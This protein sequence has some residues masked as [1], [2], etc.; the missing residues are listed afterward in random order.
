VAHW[1]SQQNR[2]RPGSPG[3]VIQ[4]ITV[5][6]RIDIVVACPT[7]AVIEFQAVGEFDLALKEPKPVGV[8]VLYQLRDDRGVFFGFT[9]K[10]RRGNPV[11]IQNVPAGGLVAGS[12][13]PEILAVSIDETGVTPRLKVEAVGPLGTGQANLQVNVQDETGS[14]M[15]SGSVDI[16]VVAGSAATVDLQPAESFDLPSA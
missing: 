4:E 1:A 9:L 7:D 15:I 13:H 12:S 11:P 5:S 16:E 10:D 14:H 2:F 3:R 6:G 8:R